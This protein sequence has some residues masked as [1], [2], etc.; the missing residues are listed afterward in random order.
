MKSQIRTL[1]VGVV[2]SGQMGSGIAF[3]LAQQAKINVIMQDISQLNL[4]KATTY[5]GTFFIYSQK[6]DLLK[7]L[8]L[9]EKIKNEDSLE[10]KKL[11][12]TS[13]ELKSLSDCD[14]IIE[15]ATENT[16]IKLKIFKDLSLITSEN[17]ILAS[18]TSSISITKIASVVKKPENVIGLHFMNPVTLNISTKGTSYEVS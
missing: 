7:K 18:N 12:T 10:I 9:K 5:H 11:I 1:K 8:V 14:I 13:Q 16:D 15:A 4:N 6:D 2:G 17:T 3:V